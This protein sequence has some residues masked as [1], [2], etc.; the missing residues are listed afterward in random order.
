MFA[1]RSCT[2]TDN[3][4]ASMVDFVIVTDLEMVIQRVN[5]AMLALF[6]Y[7][8][9]ELIG[10]SLN[11]LFSGGPFKKAVA[12]A[13]KKK[14][15][16][17]NLDK[18]IVNKSG[19]TIPVSMSMS[20]VKDESGS[21][22]G[23]VCVGRDVTGHNRAEAERKV[24]SEVIHG[25]TTTSNLDELLG[26][27]HRSIG[28]LIYAENCFV[29]LFDEK[30]EMLS[31]QFF[32]DKNDPR[33]A[34]WKLGRGLSAYVYRTG[35][36][37]LM[38]PEIIQELTDA[39]EVEIVG[40]V[41]GIWLGVPLR[42]PDGIIG[43][44]VVQHYEDPDAYDQQ[45]VEFL[46]SVAAQI[47]HVIERKRTEEALRENEA[48]FR[49]LF[50]NAPVAYH[51]LDTEGRF[52]R[53]NH[54]EELLLGYTNDELR[55]RHPW[56][57]IVETVSRDATQQKLNSDQ[58][59]EPVERTFIRKDG[60]LVSVLN[61]DRRIVDTDGTVIGMRS[62]L[63]NITALKRAEEQMAIFNEKLQNSNRELQ[64][65]AY[66]A[67]HDLQEPLRK[68]QAFSDRLKTKY[69]DKLEGEGLDYLERMR[70]AGQRMQLLIQDLLTFSR[71]STKGEPFTPVDLKTITHEV[72]SDLEVKIE[73]TG[74]VVAV[75]E[76]VSL[77]ADPMQM[78]Q[79]MQNLIGNALKFQRH[80]RTPTI[81]IGAKLGINPRNGVG[82]QM[83]K[84][85]IKDNGIGFDEKYTDKIFAVFQRLHGRTEYEG[86]GVGLAV[87]RK[88]V[89]RHYGTI[90]AASAPGE[91]ATFTINLPIKQTHM[92]MTNDAR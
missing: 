68:V 56:E 13:L 41:P 54:T 52:T 24:I 78:R 50:D 70:N 40:T 77:D 42:T 76:M 30:T 83:C 7:D 22:L 57:I 84:I 79:L 47:A 37:K 88:I 65:F 45:D 73:E 33:P 3:V 74:A 2:L 39:G 64:D 4:L 91:G 67:S 58:P 82:R 12:L 19:T 14:G 15:F 92:E 23:I 11:T 32:V 10:R 71:V 90:T 86:S 26:L 51:E 59:L 61:E 35:Q 38:T 34:P 36:P 89:E 1:T 21:E 85:T 60:T 46:C 18:P 43:V 80:D 6:G 9:H 28:S 66:V 49:D 48:R 29:A 69:G 87:C 16:A 17:V 44:L 75:G 25:V 62:T 27:I 31:T 55:G 63:Q 81:H 8:E 20:L 5:P 53:I 72:L